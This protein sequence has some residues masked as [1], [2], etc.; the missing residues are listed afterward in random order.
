MKIADT[1][2]KFLNVSNKIY[3]LKET[4][5]MFPKSH[6]NN[7]IIDKFNEIMELQNTILGNLEY[8]AKRGKYYHFF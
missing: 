5:T 8:A 7:L 2:F 3:Q 6:L 1:S 4:E